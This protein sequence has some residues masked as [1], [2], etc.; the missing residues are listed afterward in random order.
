VKLAPLFVFLAACQT[1]TAYF[2]GGPAAT[3]DNK[4]PATSVYQAQAD[5]VAEMA[6][7]YPAVKIHD[8]RWRPC[9]DENAWYSPANQT[10]TFCTEL[11]SLGG[12]AV[13]VAAHEFGHAVT[14][15]LINTTDEQDA[16]EL[17][18]LALVKLGHRT[19]LLELALWFEQFPQLGQGLG[20]E[21]P[22]AGF[23]AW[24]LAC[25]EAGSEPGATGDCK[26]LYDGLNV[27]WGMRLAPEHT[28]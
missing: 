9:G 2:H 18:A 4:H 27:R 26:A 1:G 3:A 15:Q 20:D 11:E 7:L 23:R 22:G 17:A 24:E 14:D 8:V 6:G 12:A 13:G 25:I 16:D 21:H 10:I 5:V 19:E 28:N